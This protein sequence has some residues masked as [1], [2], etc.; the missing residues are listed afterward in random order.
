MLLHMLLSL[1][2]TSV[3]GGYIGIWVNSINHNPPQ[4]LNK[5]RDK[6]K[7]QAER[8]PS[9]SFITNSAD[10]EEYSWLYGNNEPPDIH[11]PNLT[12]PPTQIQTA[13]DNGRPSHVES[14]CSILKLGER[15]KG[16]LPTGQR[17]NDLSYI[18]IPSSLSYSQQL[19]KS[20]HLP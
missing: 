7:K 10:F 14:P 8:E 15:R 19:G 16:S 3:P 11:P 4:A 9:I 1:P 12:D 13:L 20:L 18:Q 6:T 2:G 17:K 5:L